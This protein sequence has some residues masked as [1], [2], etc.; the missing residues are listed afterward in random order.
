MDVLSVPEAAQRRVSIRAYEP[1][2]IPSEDLETILDVARRAPSAFN[3]QPWR[4][5][6][7]EAP[8]VK[9]LLGLAAHVRIP[10]LVAAGR[11]AESGFEQHRHPLQRVVQAA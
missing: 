3:V 4:F 6:V 10:A 9:E 8:E 11:P 7:V 5:R 2:P 1:E